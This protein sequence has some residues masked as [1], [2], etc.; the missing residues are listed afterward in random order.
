MNDIF[1]SVPDEIIKAYS[2]DI[3]STK[4]LI[5]K[6]IPHTH[7]LANVI[8][9]L[10]LSRYDFTL[11]SYLLLSIV[12]TP[13]QYKAKDKVTRT[14]LKLINRLNYL[15]NLNT[16]VD[17]TKLDTKVEDSKFYQEELSS[18]EVIE[19]FSPYNNLLVNCIDDI[20][21]SKFD[22]TKIIH[23]LLSTI[24][25]PNR[26]NINDIIKEAILKLVNRLQELYRNEKAK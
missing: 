1:I 6:D 16:K 13:D 11:I 21:L 3:L 7:N 14:I 15:Y 23:L 20:N 4:S 25:Y 5:N 24:W 26:F 22:F 17:V 9:K 12:I 10:D 8:N 18:E 2:Q 19:D